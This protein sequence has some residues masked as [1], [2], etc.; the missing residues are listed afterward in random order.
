[1]NVKE[2][3]LRISLEQ[4]LESK[5]GFEK[6]RFNHYALPE[7]NFEDI[8]SEVVFLKK[9]FSA[10]IIIGSMTG[11]TESTGRINKKLAMVAEKKNIPFSTGSQK[12]A[13][14]KPETI[15]SFNV[16][17][18]SPK[19]FL[20]ANIGGTALLK[21]DFKV[22]EDS[23]NKVDADALFVHLNPLQEL[24]QKE[25]VRKWKGVENKI[26]DLCDYLSIP[27]LVKEV[28]NGI[29]EKVA[30]ELQNAGVKAIDV[31]GFGG[32]NWSV[33]EKS[34]INEKR[35]VFEGWGISTLESLKQ[36]AGLKI[37]LIASGGVRNGLDVAKA[38]RFGAGMSSAS[39]P[40][41]KAL[42]EGRLEQEVSDWIEELKITMMLTRSRNLKELKKAG[43]L[44]EQ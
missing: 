24:I 11:G 5:N 17:K 4:P 33:I 1:M 3:Q 39:L 12:V 37:P 2:E 18:T 7:M 22:I 32:T 41:L 25:G 15:E 10:P 44:S 14:T 6:I 42:V 21:F 40:F 34:R 13:L 43:L 31:A 23:L 8:D 9:R 28:G 36:C 20:I 35:N 38:I 30:L 27:V 16:K 19:V 26:R 29:N